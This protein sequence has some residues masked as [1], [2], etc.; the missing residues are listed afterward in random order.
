MHYRMDFRMQMRCL[1]K[2]DLRMKKIRGLFILLI[3]TLLLCGSVISIVFVFA[4]G[5]GFFIHTAFVFLPIMFLFSDLFYIRRWHKTSDNRALPEY[6]YPGMY[7]A[8]LLILYE[9]AYH[10]NLYDTQLFLFMI[11]V[12]PYYILKVIKKKTVPLYK[13][14]VT[15]GWMFLTDFIVSSL[16][17][18]IVVLILRLILNGSALTLCLLGSFKFISTFSR[19]AI[20]SIR[21]EK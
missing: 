17:N 21:R 11:F 8:L 20:D 15:S 9:L 16:E 14:F 6:F 4:R 3:F 1:L 2:S 19:V 10:L 5:Y 13:Y 18:S 7:F 12:P